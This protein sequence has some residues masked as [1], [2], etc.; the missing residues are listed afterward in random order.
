MHNVSLCSFTYLFNH[1]FFLLSFADINKIICLHGTFSFQKK[2]G[3]GKQF[4][5]HFLLQRW[6]NLGEVDPLFLAIVHSQVWCSLGGMRRCFP[7]GSG[8]N[9]PSRYTSLP[10]TRLARTTPCSVTPR[11]GP[12]CKDNNSIQIYCTVHNSIC[13][14]CKC[15][16]QTQKSCGSPYFY[17][18]HALPLS[19]TQSKN[20]NKYV[21]KGQNI[22][23]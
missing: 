7:R 8:Q 18:V 16:N 5:S 21:Y 12:S 17:D 20:F 3:G 15:P 2:K 19:A 4:G 22:C 13:T 14:C 6:H 1:Y 9:E 11:Y 23:T 10:L